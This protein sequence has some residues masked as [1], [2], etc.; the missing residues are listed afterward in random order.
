MSTLVV[1][2]PGRPKTP[3]DYRGRQGGGHWRSRHANNQTW[4]AAGVR[5]ALEVKPADWEP[6]TRC[7][8]TVEFIVPTRARRDDDNLIAAQKPVLDGIVMA[9]ILADDSNRV[10]AERV[11][12]PQR[13]EKGVQATVYTFESVP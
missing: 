2:V 6:L 10:I 11:Y 12:L 13:Y 8:L 9:G 7:R 5:A 1:T 4:K 3:N